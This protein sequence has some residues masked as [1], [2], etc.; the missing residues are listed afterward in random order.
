ML[1]QRRQ[2]QRQ[3][4]LETR[5]ASGSVRERGQALV[6]EGSSTRGWSTGRVVSRRSKT[7]DGTGGSA[8]NVAVS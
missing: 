7:N 6:V 2:Q 1:V 3:R 4:R 8:P 5:A